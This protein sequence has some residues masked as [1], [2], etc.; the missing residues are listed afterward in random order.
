[1]HDEAD[2]VVGVTPPDQ[3]GQADRLGYVVDHR[4]SARVGDAE[5]RRQDAVLEAGDVKAVHR[6]GTDRRRQFQGEPS[7]AHV[8]ADHA[9]SNGSGILGVRPGLQ[10]PAFRQCLDDRLAAASGPIA[11]PTVERQD[12]HLRIREEHGFGPLE[13]MVGMRGSHPIPGLLGRGQPVVAVGYVEGP[14]A[15]RV[16]QGIGVFAGRGPDRLV[17]ALAGG[18]QDRLVGGA[19]GD[20]GIQRLVGP[21]GERDRAGGHADL[22]EVAGQQVGPTRPD[23]LMA[24]DPPVV[25]VRHRN[26]AQDPGLGVVSHLH[27]VQE[28]RRLFVFH[29]GA[30]VVDALHGGGAAGE[31]AVDVVAL[32]GCYVLLGARHVQEAVRVGFGECSPLFRCVGVVRAGG[33]A[34]SPLGVD[35]QARKAPQ[36]VHWSRPRV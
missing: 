17:D 36:D 21:V 12:Q 19:R 30:G 10:G 20:H 7:A 28:Q 6:P 35:D 2:P 15:H 33:D 13:W 32:V 8:D 16:D 24:K 14:V 29:V 27:P 23:R 11:H 25:G 4:I 1:M 18:L 9:G 22:Q 31:E 26:H 34:V 3:G 5:R